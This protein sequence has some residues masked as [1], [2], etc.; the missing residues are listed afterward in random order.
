MKCFCCHGAG[1]VK[2]VEIKTTAN[3]VTVRIDTL[4]LCALCRDFAVHPWV[5]MLPGQRLHGP[6]ETAA[7]HLDRVQAV[8]RAAKQHVEEM[9]E[10]EYSAHLREG[11]S[12]DD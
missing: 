11:G 9:D 5:P 7:D 3:G 4:P 12:D 1:G 2:P 6:T 8:F 10:D